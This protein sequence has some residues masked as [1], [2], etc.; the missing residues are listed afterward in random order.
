MG[1]QALLHATAT[2][3]QV[4][5]LRE[6]GMQQLCLEKPQD[7]YLGDKWN[8]LTC[9]PTTASGGGYLIPVEIERLLS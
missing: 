4:L 5:K 7:V 3:G 1:L 2:H 8:V 6:A 9:A